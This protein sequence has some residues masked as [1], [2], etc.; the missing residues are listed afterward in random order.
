MKPMIQVGASKDAVIAARRAIID[1]LKVHN[2]DQETK[3]TALNVLSQLCEVKNTNI[4]HCN[5]QEGK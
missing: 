5:F 4:T 2:V 1:I 3:R